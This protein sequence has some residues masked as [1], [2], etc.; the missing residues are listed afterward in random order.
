M[1]LSA[2]SVRELPLLVSERVKI[3]V[4]GVALSS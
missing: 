3:G 2:L 1:R 4:L